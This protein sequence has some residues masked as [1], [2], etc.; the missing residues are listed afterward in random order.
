MT[1]IEDLIGKEFIRDSDRRV[2]MMTDLIKAF[3]NAGK[4][5]ANKMFAHAH[6]TTY[7]PDVSMTDGLSRVHHLKIWPIEYRAA[8]NGLKP[9]EFRLNDRSFEM[10]DIVI[11]HQWHPERKQY[12]TSPQLR[13]EITYI[14][15]EGF[16]IP[17][18]HVILTLKEA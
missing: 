12:L 15:R 1:T 10:G 6:T 11:L 8:A 16:G 3:D 18:N 2:K 5:M 9:W 14:Q 13:R 7:Q 4:P 17:A